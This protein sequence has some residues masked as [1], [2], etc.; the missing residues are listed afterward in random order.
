MSEMTQY[1]YQARIVTLVDEFHK[2]KKQK[3]EYE[4]L[5]HEEFKKSDGWKVEI[6]KL[7]NVIA[8]LKKECGMIGLE[9][10][11]MKIRL[12]HYVEGN[13]ELLAEIQTL[14]RNQLDAKSPVRHRSDAEIDRLTEPLE[15]EELKTLSGFR[16]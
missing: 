12:D 14:L 3:E 15:E 9:N 5:Y 8:E 6:T 16:L 10:N 7:N 11:G 13:N 2:M 4:D 1:E